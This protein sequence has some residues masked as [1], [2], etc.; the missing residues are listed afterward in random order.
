[1]T[2]N[3]TKSRKSP[4]K[5]QSSKSN[6]NHPVPAAIHEAGRDS[7]RQAMK[8]TFYF[9]HDFNARNDPKLQNV[10]MEHGCAGIGVFWCIV[11]QLHEQDGILPLAGINGIA[12]ALH[13]DVKVVESIIRDFDLFQADNE[14]FWSQ[15]VNKRLQKR[16]EIKDKR[17]KAAQ[18]RWA[19]KCKSNA[20]AMHMQSKEKERKEN[21]SSN[22]DNNISSSNEDSSTSVDPASQ[23]KKIVIDYSRIMAL[24]KENCPGFPQPRTLADDDK[25]KVRQ[26][27]NEMSSGDDPE[28]AY[29]RI[30]AI[31]KKIGNSDFCKSGKWC[32]FRW[33]FKNATNWRKVEDG[34]YD[35]NPADSGEKVNDI[36]Q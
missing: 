13:V 23:E 10:L 4:R 21:I 27:F 7:K 1:M 36:W 30:E 17:K 9:Q 5:S 20:N 8:D 22:E 32:S 31:F 18:H 14:N 33:V 6:I 25:S 29:Q 34:N 28:T 24:W 3:L 11:E 35:N 2:N 19:E 12:F 15:S 26:R 16:V